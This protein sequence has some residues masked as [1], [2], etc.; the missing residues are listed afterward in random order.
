MTGPDPVLT[1]A[2]YLLLKAGTQFH[3]VI[4]AALGAED[5]TG[6]QFLVLTFA[7]GAEG[8]SQLELSRRLHLD[9]TI[10]VGLLD[11]LEDRGLV[12]RTKDPA[13]RRRHLIALTTD[14]RKLQ[15]R[16]AKAVAVA[17]RD[18]LEPLSGADRKQLRRLLLDVMQ[19]RLPWLGDR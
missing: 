16:A 7:G 12:T 15:A 2:G 9:P 13:D 8:L 11:E 4:D 19:S 1:S 18:F 14:G 5:L 10:V 3:G 6:R 17:E